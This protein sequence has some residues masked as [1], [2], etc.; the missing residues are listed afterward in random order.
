[1]GLVVYGEAKGRRRVGITCDACG[2]PITSGDDGNALWDGNFGSKDKSW[3]EGSGPSGTAPMLF[4]HKKCDYAAAGKI[5]T[6]SL[7]NVAELPVRLITDMDLDL[8][9]TVIEVRSLR[10]FRKKEPA[11]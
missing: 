4:T 1:V 9:E 10:D 8:D 3:P 11:A 5:Y 6:Q 2:E 7:T